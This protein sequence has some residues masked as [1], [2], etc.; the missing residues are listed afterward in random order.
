MGL[1]FLL[2]G[3]LCQVPHYG[4]TCDPSQFEYMMENWEDEIIIPVEIHH[5]GV[6]YQGCTMRIR[7]DSSRSERKKSYRVEFPEDQPHLG[8]TSWNFNAEFTDHS[9]MR[10]WLFSRVLSQMGFPVF[11]VAHATLSV[12][13]ENRGLFIR[14]EPVNRAFLRRNAINDQGNLY[15]ARYDGA[16]AGIHDDIENAWTKQTN[17][18]SGMNDLFDL[19][20][21]IEYCPSSEF[22]AFMD[23][24]FT[25]YGPHG[26]IRMLA[27]NSVFANNST[28]YHNYYLYNDALGTGGWMMIPWDTDKVLTDNLGIGYSGATNK[29]WHDN[30]IYS[31]TLTEP[32]FREAFID[33]VESIHQFWL[34]EEKIA[35]WADSLAEVLQTAVEEDTWDQTDYQGFL[36]ELIVLQE[37]MVKRRTDLQWQFQYKYYPFRSWR[38]PSVSTG[39]LPVSWSPATDPMGNP[40][41]YSVVVRDI[42]GP[43]AQEIVRYQGIEDTLFVIPGLPPGSYWW[44]VET[45]KQAGWRYTEATDRYNPFS[46][47]QPVELSGTL[48]GHTRLY[49]ALSPY[50]ITGDLTIAPGATLE[51]ESGVTL[52]VAP[53]AA[54]D[55]MGTIL[56]E[57]QPGDSIH[58]MPENHL[59]GWRGIRLQN[60]TVELNHTVVSGSRGY[61]SSPGA[62]FAALAGHSSDVTITESVFRNNWSCVKLHGG[63][64]EIVNSVF[65]NNRGEMFYMKDG[66]GALISGSRFEN[67]HD[68][69]A[70]SMDGI[71]FELCT[72]GQ[73]LVVDCIL[74]N[75]ADDGIDMNASSVSIT[76]TTIS[77]VPD[78]GFSIGAPTGGSGAGTL[79]TIENCIIEDCV[80]GLGIKDGAEVEADGL[81]IRSSGTAVHLYEK[82]GGMGGGFVEIVNSIFTQCD[83]DIVVE[84][85]Y[86]H[87]NWSLTD[88]PAIPGEGNITGNPQLDGSGYLLWNSP[89]IDAGNPSM[90]D[91]D[92]SRRD[93]GPRF[94]PTR[95]QGL[96][97]NEMM[98]I[99]N[100]TVTDDWGRFSDWI[101]L[102][103]GTGYDLDAGVLVFAQGD[104][105]S[106]NSWSVER[107]TM[108]PG[109]GFMLFWADGEGWKGGNHLPFRLSGDGEVFHVGRL[110]PGSGEEPFVSLVEQVVF[111]PQTPDV[112]I[113]RFP[114]GGPWRVLDIPTP[115]WSNGA[116]YSQQVFMTLP[117]PNPCRTGQVT[118]DVTV[119]GGETDVYVYDI[120]GRRLATL[121]NGYAEQGEHTLEW[122]TSKVPAG[123]YLILARCAGQTPATGKFTV[124]R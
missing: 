47:V 37:N 33:T 83:Y 104:Y 54:V 123:V 91:P 77:G 17:G 49:R 32:V 94:F 3:L 10:S 58:I 9:Y 31:R 2:L 51:I 93:I 99:N 34:T 88:G 16:C 46:V 63:T 43:D 85:G 79:V 55:C 122:D 61:A 75:M 21:G 108:I 102:Y 38:S 40:A 7:G 68:P 50:L 67:L 41:T 72:R 56:A 14:L 57:G 118:F 87:V 27:L 96:F 60:G 119:A 121:M 114:D 19:I 29:N 71:E 107:G 12:N 117:R 42:L 15:K 13:G 92:G 116:L 124:L 23:S 35:F 20:H 70:G 73:F 95:M 1:H 69:V 8:R 97:V 113:G 5:D 90:T 98:A 28:Y 36:H 6:V 101:E 52:L 81:L 39:E 89:C 105:P 48:S 84:E 115:G 62:N 80:T 24:A 106:S 76:G 44:T 82:T 103:N 4:I 11:Q 64:V 53:E 18:S 74:Q 22:Q 45:E 66:E 59:E 100:T 86:A 109:G 120:A 78:K 110:V 111:G 112:S 25:M 30:P 26:L 65:M